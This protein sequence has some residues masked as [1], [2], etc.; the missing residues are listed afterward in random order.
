MKELFH[1]PEK[2][3]RIS[4]AC[5]KLMGPWKEMSEQEGKPVVFVF[6]DDSGEIN[7]QNVMPA[8][9]FQT[10]ALRQTEPQPA[11]PGQ[12]KYADCQVMTRYPDDN[13][14]EMMV[15]CLSKAE[16][17]N[18]LGLI[19]DK[20]MFSAQMKQKANVIVTLKATR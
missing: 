6:P 20:G 19:L 1:G 18:L 16:I 8:P 14:V 5:E 2:V 12:G 15:E 3:V 17:S 10:V 13:T 9:V 11:A 4:V 7:A